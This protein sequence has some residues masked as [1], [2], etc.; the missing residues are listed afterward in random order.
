[1]IVGSQAN[2]S[3]CDGYKHYGMYDTHGM[4]VE[5]QKLHALDYFRAS[6]SL[7]QYWAGKYIT[8]Q[9]GYVEDCMAATKM[10]KQYIM[11]A[12]GTFDE[13]LRLHIVFGL[14]ALLYSRSFL[15]LHEQI[16]GMIRLT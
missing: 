12:P 1:M 8:E 7:H 2:R 16:G 14:I 4:R 11:P 6:R 10:L 9:L 3:Y 5:F 13:P 15:K